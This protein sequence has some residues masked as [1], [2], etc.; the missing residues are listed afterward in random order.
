MLSLDVTTTFVPRPGR[1]KFAL[2]VCLVLLSSGAAA[3]TDFVSV[4]RFAPHTSTVTANA[5]QRVGI[6][7]HEKLAR[8]TAN[9]LAARTGL[10][11]GRA[12]H[13]RHLGAVGRRLRSR[14]SRL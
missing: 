13:P 12:I 11:R 4:D 2:I 3:Q 1:R 7:V 6:F 10:R 5:R 8:A 14:L 9:A